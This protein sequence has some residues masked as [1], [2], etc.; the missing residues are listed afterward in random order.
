MTTQ[1]T[2]VAAALLA[3]AQAT[4]FCPAAADEPAAQAQPQESPGAVQAPPDTKGQSS[5][6]AQMGSADSLPGTWECYG[7][8]QRSPRTPPIVYF[9][10]VQHY[11]GGAASIFVDG[12][13]RAVN[14]RARVAAE[15]DA[16]LVTLA[17]SNL[18]LHDFSDYGSTVRMVLDRDGVG[19]YRCYRLPGHGE[20]AEE[21]SAAPQPQ[22]DQV[23]VQGTVHPHVYY[24]VE[25]TYA[26]AEVPGLEPYAAP[27][28]EASAPSASA[29]ARAD[30]APAAPSPAQ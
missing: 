9:A 2:V 18:R 29:A 25:R 16:L 7:P 15:P 20:P 10:A 12:F 21:S 11:D 14:G 1:R 13:A 4:S 27:P 8:G 17:D 28:S 26:P 23:A 22:G 19:T 6:P 24:P 5:A 3:I 30:A